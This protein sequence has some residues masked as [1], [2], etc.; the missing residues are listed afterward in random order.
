MEFEN[1]K[2]SLIFEVIEEEK[3]PGDKSQASMMSYLRGIGQNYNRCA[4]RHVSDEMTRHRVMTMKIMR[5]NYWALVCFYFRDFIEQISRVSKADLR[6][7]GPQYIAN[8]ID[9][10]RVK[11]V[12]VCHSNKA[13]KVARAM[14]EQ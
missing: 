4:T 8:V 7:V 1:A 5:L 12:V 6:R 14:S 13:K 11:S 3:T 10:T 9:P 2:S